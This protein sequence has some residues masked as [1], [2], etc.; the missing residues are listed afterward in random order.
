MPCSLEQAPC[1]QESPPWPPLEQG[2]LPLL[3]PS[4]LTWV[5]WGSR[6]GGG[7]RCEPRSLE[8]YTHTG[9]SSRCW[10]W[11][12]W[13]LLWGPEVFRFGDGEMGIQDRE[14]SRSKG[15]AWVLPRMR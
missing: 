6:E 14:N 8:R 11:G 12:L 1:R 13:G 4:S 9:V 7:V 5:P 3:S 10:E 2:G 15:K